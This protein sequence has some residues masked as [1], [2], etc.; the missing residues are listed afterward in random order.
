M[1]SYRPSYKLC[2]NCGNSTYNA[3]SG[4][5][6]CKHYQRKVDGDADGTGCWGWKSGGS[7]SSSSSN[8]GCFLTSACVKHLGKADDCVELQTLR[9]FRDGYMSKTPEGVHLIKTYYAVAPQI[10]QKIDNSATPAHYYDNIYATICK[11]LQL[12]KQNKL[13]ETIQEYKQMVL[14]LQQEFGLI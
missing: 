12:I 9:Q 3:S 5:Y 7:N 4:T 1:P 2:S 6:Y 11:C 13:D 10:V 8:D 14:S